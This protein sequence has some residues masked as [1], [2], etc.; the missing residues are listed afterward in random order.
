[1]ILPQATS[2]A[3]GPLAA[4]AILRLSVHYTVAIGDA[5]SD[6]ELLRAAEVGVAVAWGSESLKKAADY[7]LSGKGP[8]L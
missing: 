8:R 6:H 7:V 5:E 4:L 3:T 2:K 1:M